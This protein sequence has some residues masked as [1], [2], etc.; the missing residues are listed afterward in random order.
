[1]L[2]ACLQLLTLVT[3]EERVFLGKTI[4]DHRVEGLTKPPEG[5]YLVQFRDHHSKVLPLRFLTSS[6]DLP[7]SYVFV[8]MI[9]CSRQRIWLIQTRLCIC[10]HIS[11]LWPWGTLRAVIWYT[12]SSYLRIWLFLE[13]EEPLWTG[14]A[15]NWQLL[16]PQWA[17]RYCE[18]KKKRLCYTY[19]HFGLFCWP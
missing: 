10:S 4:S 18:K 1:M 2:N 12:W 16:S 8:S 9:K 19:L 11:Q 3:E 6:S 7:F 13:K 15:P 5:W 14:D 17:N